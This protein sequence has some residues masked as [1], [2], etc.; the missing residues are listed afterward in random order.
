MGSD[1]S[2]NADAASTEAG[3]PDYYELLQINEDAT[4]DEIK[5]SYRKLALINHP[6]KN[7]HRTEE[8]TK[9]FADLQ[10]AYEILSDPNERAFYDS[11]RNAFVATTDNDVFDHVR[12]GDS[13]AHD[14]KS[15]LNR[16]R[17]GDPGVRLEQLLR[18]FDPKL[19]KRMDDST[20]GFYSVYR[21]LF[22]LL[23]QDEQL[24]TLPGDS[25]PIYPGFGNS[26]TSYAPP[27]GSTRSEREAHMWAR[28]FYTGWSQFSTAKRFEWVGKWDVERGEDRNIRRLMEKGNKKVRDEYR[29][30]YNDT[31]RQL[32][33]F[34][35]HRDPRFKLFQNHAQRKRAETSQ[36]R[37]GQSDVRSAASQAQ[38]TADRKR[39]QARLQAAAD[40]VEQDW[41]KVE[42]SDSSEEEQEEPAQDGTAL[43]AGEFL[44]CVACAKTFQSEASWQ[45]H[46][47][48]KKHKQSVWRLKRDMQADDERLYLS[49]DV[50]PSATETEAVHESLS[51]YAEIEEQLNELSMSNSLDQHLTVAE[52]ASD[53]TPPGSVADQANGFSKPSSPLPASRAPQNDELEE[54]SGPT[55]A[56]KRDKR[57]A[58]EARKKAEEEAKREAL[59]I[60]MRE[61][62][63]IA[64]T[65]EGPRDTSAQQEE[66]LRKRGDFIPVRGKKAIGAKGRRGKD[67]LVFD[68]SDAAIQSAVAGIREKRTKMIEKW[69]VAWQDYLEKLSIAL[70]ADEGHVR[71]TPP[72]IDRCL[73]LGIGKV[74]TDRSAQVQMGLLLELIDQFKIATDSVEIYDPE[75]DAGDRKVL[76]ELGLTVLKEN[77]SGRHVLDIRCSYLVYMPH[78]P[79]ELYEEFLAANFTPR[80]GQ[81]PRYLLLG[82]DLAEYDANLTRREEAVSPARL[83][84]P[85][86]KPK[87]KRKGKTGAHREPKDGTLSR[88]VPQTRWLPL[89]ILPDTN[90]PGFAR[91]LLSLGVQ[92]LP[93]EN[94]DAVDWDTPLPP[95]ERL[96]SSEIR[97]I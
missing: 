82:N 46:E 95:I 8:A 18:F 53:S 75:W 25:T 79:K 19:A 27:A 51:D 17:A 78:C 80:L 72:G 10:Q 86:E 40:Y 5:R 16:R 54:G 55:G 29:K 93:A 81:S 90:L 97:D 6:D 38:R 94:V 41:Q 11:H 33:L 64:R 73:C 2:R 9:I 24:H 61:A 62:R 69:G 83:D 56:T 63:K 74:L 30:E 20:E 28:D 58:R 88:I 45:N 26:E 89:S 1:Q 67:D 65:A 36:G 68:V 37:P 92:W 23:A 70:D 42:A 59:K 71:P 47:R 14:P 87:R 57:R 21:N 52:L 49:P 76:Q 15:K 44:E 60:A 22:A 31:V 4:S 35:Q 48:S 66:K 13:A 43:R 77:K 85:F 7:P 32:A 84:E 3:P 12:S 34:V 96:E 50:E 39:E 91:A